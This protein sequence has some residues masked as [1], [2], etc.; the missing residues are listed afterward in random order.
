[1]YYRNSQFIG[2]KNRERSVYKIH[3][4]V[5]NV[6]Y[7]VDRTT[8]EIWE[9]VEVCHGLGINPERLEFTLRQLEEE[10]LIS[11]VRPTRQ[12]V[13]IETD[14]DS[15]DTIDVRITQ[16]CNLTCSYC[17]F[18]RKQAPL[19]MSR[20]VMET[21]AEE[22]NRNGIPHVI[23]SGGEPFLNSEIFNLLDSISGNHFIS[24]ATNGTLLTSQIVQNLKRLQ[25]NDVEISLDA[26]VDEIN[27]ITRGEGTFKSI[28]DGIDLLIKN[29]IVPKISTTLT[30]SNFRFIPQ[31]VSFC[32][33]RGIKKIIIN[34]LRPD[35]K[36]LGSH[37]L[38]LTDDDYK[39][40]S[41]LIHDLKEQYADKIEV[42]HSGLTDICM[43]PGHS[44]L[45]W[46]KSLV[47]NGS[48][49]Y[50]IPNGRIFNCSAGKRSVCIL[51]NGDVAPCHHLQNYLLGNVLQSPLLAVWRDSEAL[52]SIRELKN[53][54]TKTI[55]G[56]NVCL[57][58]EICSGGCRA[59][60]YNTTGDFMA[61]FPNCP[62]R[63]PK[64][65][66]LGGSNGKCARVDNDNAAP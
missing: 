60:C 66:I 53:V 15:I 49:N 30:T 35:G 14:N 26:A 18:H 13:I 27:N 9:N 21:V 25:V 34:E 31:L 41:R 16:N 52:K 7:A 54:P 48:D 38:F 37:H 39:V 42:V 1:M 24:I 4:V 44:Y 29:D 59:I 17:S 43:V 28:K 10:N 20:A 2:V 46:S 55:V 62:I 65:D 19:D 56:C 23:I 51:P 5:R 47:A 3:S 40:A 11:K 12:S 63:D 50:S 36:A 8:F 33:D 61:Q 58:S 22:I 32:F 6:R 64:N 45:P 57:Y